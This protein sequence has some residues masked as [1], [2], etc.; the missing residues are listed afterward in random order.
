MG[1]AA[2]MGW[3]QSLGRNHLGAITWA[4]SLGRSYLVPLYDGV[5]IPG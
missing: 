2:K 3:A 4:Q 5:V 1:F